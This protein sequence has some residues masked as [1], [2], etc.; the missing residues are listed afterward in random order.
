MYNLTVCLSCS[1]NDFSDESWDRFTNIVAD[2]AEEAIREATNLFEKEIRSRFRERIYQD[3]DSD[4]DREIPI[5]TEQLLVRIA[6]KRGES[7]QGFRLLRRELNITSTE[8]QNA[9]KDPRYP[10]IVRVISKSP[11]ASV[12][13][14][15]MCKRAAKRK[16]EGRFDE[17]LVINLFAKRFLLTNEIARPIA[18]EL[19]QELSLAKEY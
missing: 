11:N 10:E 7:K 12:K 9:L 16:I 17:E 15:D 3:E 19:I 8:L 18:L 13:I 4:E 2:D 1:D 5:F 6:E 14:R